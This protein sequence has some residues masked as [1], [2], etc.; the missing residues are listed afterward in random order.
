[1]PLLDCHWLTWSAKVGLYGNDAEQ[2]SILTGTVGQRADSPADT[3]AFVGEFKIGLEVPLTHC[4]SISSGYTLFLM[5][6][7]AVASDQLQATNFFTGTGSDDEGN[8]L[9]HGG[10]VAL[11]LQF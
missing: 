6:R 2:T 4:V 9:F 1:M 8:A 7:V 11:T 10:S 3:A 5:Q